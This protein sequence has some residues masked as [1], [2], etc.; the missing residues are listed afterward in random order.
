M[1]YDRCTAECQPEVNAHDLDCS[2]DLERQRVIDCPAPP[3]PVVAELS[4]QGDEI[5]IRDGWRLHALSSQQ[6]RVLADQINQ[7]CEMIEKRE[8]VL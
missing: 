6:A 4:L 5:L 2:L 7:A 8:A 3:S 1:R